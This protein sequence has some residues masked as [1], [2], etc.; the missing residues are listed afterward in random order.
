MKKTIALLLV[1]AVL[2]AVIVASF[3]GCNL[4]KSI[5]LDEVQTNLQE[6]GYEVTVLTGEQFVEQKGEE[7]PFIFAHELNNYL[8]GVKGE[9]KI[10]VFFFTTIDN[11]SGN[12]DTMHSD[13]PKSGQSNEV[14]YFATK[15]AQKDAKI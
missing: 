13:L 11:A 4:F 10:E 7:Y 12:Y 9:E 1:V 14:V 3:A 2:S 6:A 5:S 8:Y 15:Q